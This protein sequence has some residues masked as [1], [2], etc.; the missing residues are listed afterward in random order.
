MTIAR[1]TRRWLGQGL[2]AGLFAALAPVAFSATAD[3][4]QK[5]ITLVVPFSPGG[6]ADATARILGQK[7]ETLLGQPVVVANRPG[8]GSSIGA[9]AVASAPADGYTLFFTS[10]SAY[11]YLRLLVPSYELGL[12]DFTPVAGV[13]SNPSIIAVSTSLPVKSL[14]ELVAYAQKN[15]NEIS[16]CS[17]GTGG[18]NHLQLEMFKRVVKAK[19]GHDFEVT[20]VPYNGL[21]PALV[22]IR[23]HSVQACT[24]P[25]A[26]LVKNLQGKDLRILAVQ[27]GARLPWLPQVPTTGEQGYPEMDANEEFFNIEAPK[28]TPQP[29]IA[30]LEGAI[31]EALQDPTV[32]SKLAGFEVQ[33]VFM[34]S[35]DTQKWL[36]EDVHRLSTIIHDAGLG[37]TR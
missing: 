8:A 14:G 28:G 4:P 30:K 18:L 5:P 7:L 11:G 6:S 34:S 19:T 27:S 12:D 3:F 35:P 25:Y 15:P 26:G 37:I 13:A 10:G 29:V 33:P 21:A 31:R 24:L 32:R 36:H 20:H 17:T 22:G 23:G 2:L 9:R 1:F 16:F